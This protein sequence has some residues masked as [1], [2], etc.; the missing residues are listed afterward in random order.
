MSLHS[1]NAKVRGNAIETI[2]SGV[3][4]ATF[5]Q[6]KPLLR[7]HRPV[8]GEES[9]EGDIDDLLEKALRSGRSTEAAAAADILH[10]MLDDAAFSRRMQSLVCP[11]M[12]WVLRGQLLALHGLAKPGCP[13]ALQILEALSQSKEFGGATL[14]SLLTLAEKARWSEPD[15]SALQISVKDTP[16]WI[17]HSDIRDIATRYSDLALVLLRSMDGRRYA[18]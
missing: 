5:R 8:A 2:E 17:L 9:G 13:P 10:E 11:D 3:D 18:A 7:A 14:E 15:G 1:A 6:L 4:N 12:P 16:G